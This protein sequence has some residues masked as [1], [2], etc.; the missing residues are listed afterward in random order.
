[1]NVTKREFKTLKFS[2]ELT[3]EEV[4][5]LAEICYKV[6]EAMLLDDKEHPDEFVQK[7]AEFQAQFEQMYIDGINFQRFNN[8]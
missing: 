6:K 8:V 7:V 1:M 2:V 4:D 3:M 5:M